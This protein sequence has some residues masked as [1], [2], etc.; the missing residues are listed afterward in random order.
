MQHAQEGRGDLGEVV[1]QTHLDPGR[2]HGEGLDE[3]LDVGIL[4]FVRL[5]QQLAR[6]CRIAVGEIA[7]LAPDEP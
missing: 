5:E 1:V 4:A 6:H 7:Q 2:E 3:A